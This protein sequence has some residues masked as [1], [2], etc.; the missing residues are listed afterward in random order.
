MVK[1]YW[2]IL[3]LFLGIN[4]HGSGNR[5]AIQNLN[6]KFGLA[7]KRVNCMFQDSKGFIWVGMINGLYKFDQYSFTFI[8]SKKNKPHEF[9]EADV[10]SI[11]EIRPGLMLIGTFDKGL[12]FYDT[13]LERSYEIEG[14]SSTDFSK[15]NVKCLYVDKSNIIWIGTYNGLY[16]I[17]FTGLT[18]GKIKV[19][20]I[21]E[22]VFNT[23]VSSDFI[24]FQE[25]EPGIVWFATMNDIG[26]YNTVKKDFKAHPLYYHSVS[27]FSVLDKKRI[28]IGFFG[29]GVKIL[30]TGTFKLEPVRIKGIS[31]KAL[32]RSVYKD[33]NSNIWLNISNEGL[34]FLESGLKGASELII[35]NKNIL[36]SDLNSNVIY[37]INESRD[38]A[39]WV[40]GEDGINIVKVKKDYFKSY[41]SNI[42]SENTGSHVGIRAVFDSGNGF[43]WTGTIGG[44]LKQFDLETKKFLDVALQQEGK[45]LGNTIQAILQ[46][47][48]GNLWLGTEGEGLIRFYPDKNSG[49]RKGQIVNYRMFPQIVSG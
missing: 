29:T 3:L 42:Y 17:K 21:R 47:H 45:G 19:Q 4:V 8:S 33:R 34:V 30:D 37:Q 44:G 24:S 14:D 49:Y 18:A 15:L 25:T 9:P 43:I 1:K 11:V 38:G 16:R 46:D 48:Q 12:K 26:Y 35:S 28:L 5:V 2:L 31:E 27:S 36:Y 6:E 22:K 39:I 13:E 32:V 20:H 40:C 7:K 41:N 23:L 10:R